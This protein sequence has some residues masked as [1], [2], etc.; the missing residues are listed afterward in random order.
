[1]RVTDDE[2][3]G[4]T[5]S[6]KAKRGSGSIFPGALSLAIGLCL[7][8][9]V[10]VYPLTD[11]W[12][13]RFDEPPPRP[14]L[15]PSVTL[16]AVANT[17]RERRRATDDQRVAFDFSVEERHELVA[18]L[19]EVVKLQPLNAKVLRLLAQI[20]LAEGETETADAAFRVAYQ[21]SRRDLPSAT[22][23]MRAAFQQRDATRVIDYADGIMR[24]RRDGEA[25]ALPFLVALARMPEAVFPLVARLAEEPVWR[26]A[27]L[28]EL[29][30]KTEQPASIT[31]ILLQLATTEAPPKHA[32]IADAV[33][34]LTARKR[35]EQAYGLWLNFL[36]I[37]DLARI[38]L[39]FNSDFS[40]E[41]WQHPFDWRIDTLGGLIAE[42][43][44][45]PDGGGNRAL[46][47]HFVVGRGDLRTISQTVLLSPGRYRLEGRHFGQITGRRGLVWRLIC[48]VP[49]PNRVMQSDEIFGAGQNWSQFAATFDVQP[50]CQAHRLG[51]AFASD[52]EA[53][54]L[55]R[56][57]IYFDDIRLTRVTD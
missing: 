37:E 38:G 28:A 19:R 54:K 13:A 50:G 42:V 23:M 16:D 9:L 27:F 33:R 39:V 25:V 36:E 30:Q 1:M 21:V 44:E 4:D 47:V 53:D 24:S 49:K 26:P 2:A 56:G 35:F 11:A 45:T 12:V 22:W 15:V 17:L 34:R 43:T 40:S 51:L 32:E 6:N 55:N 41:R 3:S 20:R 31:A 5:S 57:R 8:V 10:A 7:M 18:R 52:I 48:L 29:A 14:R 46:S